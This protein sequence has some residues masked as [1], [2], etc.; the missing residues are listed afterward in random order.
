VCSLWLHTRM[1]NVAQRGI[2]EMGD[3]E[4]TEDD[5]PKFETWQVE[6]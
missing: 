5:T 6:H 4:R 3:I 2:D 1:M